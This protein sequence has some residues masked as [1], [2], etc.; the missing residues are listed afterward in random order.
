VD[1]LA[2]L[3]RHLP[4]T[5]A[6]LAGIVLAVVA[7][8][9][10]LV[11]RRRVPPPEAAELEPVAAGNAGAAGAVVVDFRQAGTHH[12]LGHAFRRALAE[13]RRHLGAGDSRY[14]LPW[15][16]LLG[17]EAADRSR[18]FPESGLN[19]PLG[20]PAEPS[21]ER[22]EGCAFWFFDR[23]VVIDVSSEYVLSADGRT[24]NE[25][26]WRHFLSLLREHRLERPLDG[27]VIAI[28][29]AELV[30]PPEG[31]GQRLTAAS[32]KGEALFRKLRQAQETLRMNFP[33]YVLVTGCDEI[34][35]FASYV[36]EIPEHLRGDLFGWSSPY[37]PETAFRPEWLDEAFSQL[38]TGLHRT[39]VDAFG[40]QAFL[41][42]PDGVFSFPEDFLRLRDPLRVYLN[43]IFR[44]SAYHELLPCRGLYFC[45]QVAAGEEGA[46]LL[47]GPGSVGRSVFVRDTFDRK[48]FPE[49]DLARPNSLAMLQGGRRL[50][51]LQA[52]VV[53]LALISTLGLWWSAHDLRGRKRDLS[54]F[55][56]TTAVDLEEQRKRVARGATE[57][58]FGHDKAFTLF[59]G[60]AK[61][62]AD[63]FG[64]VFIPS[65]W[66]SPFHRELKD[67]MVRAYNEIILKT[68][69]DELGEKVD[70]ILDKARPAGEPA[71]A[72]GHE[73]HSHAEPGGEEGHSHS[74][75]GPGAAAPGDRFIA[76]EPEVTKETAP[77]DLRPLQE[78]PDFK[79]L[80]QYVASLNELESQVNRFNGLRNT[81]SLDDLKSLVRF[82]FERDLP[83]GFFHNSALYSKALADVK[84]QR[85]QPLEHRP[86]TTHQAVELGSALF[87]RLFARDP[88][89]DDLRRAATLVGEMADP[90]VDPAGGDSMANLTELRTRL[91]RAE[92][93]LAAP[94]LAWLSGET[95]DLGPSWH[96]LLQGV[97]ATI[98]LGPD[99]ADSL[100]KDGEQRFQELRRGILG[101]ETRST[102]RLVARDVKSGALGLSAEAKLLADAL[103]GLSRQGFAAAVTGEPAG[104]TLTPMRRAMW[105]TAALQQAVALYKPYE[106][107][108]EKTLAAF[109][110]ELRGALQASARDRLGARMMERTAAARRPVAE[111]G[112]ASE[113]AVAQELDAEMANFLAAAAPLGELMDRFGKLGLAADRDQV[114]ATFVAQGEQVLAD[115]DRLLS[116]RSPYTPREGGFAWWKGRRPPANEAFDARD[117][118]DLAAYLGA[119]RG[120][121]A[122]LS[123]RYA[124]P[125]I[126]ALQPLG[127]RGFTPALR[128][129]ITRWTVIADQLHRYAGKDPDN[130][131]SG[132]E[133]FILKDLTEIDLANCNGRITPRMLAEPAAD[134]F[135]ERRAKLRRDVRTRCLVLAGGWAAE[136]YGKL[137]DFFNQRLAGRFPFAAAPP[138]RL[139]AE[140]EP[141]DLRAFFQLYDAYAP[142]VRG[143]SEAEQPVEAGEFIERMRVVR[144]LFASYLDPKQTTG[145][146]ALDL[147]VR[148]RENRRA[149]KGGDQILRWALASGEQVATHSNAR[150]TLPWVY[151]APVRL[152]LQW[153]KDSPVVPVESADLAGVSVEGRTAVVERKGRW[154]L[155]ALLRALA[156]PQDAPDATTQM[157]RLQVAT[158]PEADAKAKPETARVYIAVSLRAPERT[159]KAAAAK[160]AKD[161]PLPTPAGDLELPVF[162]VSAPAWAPRS[163]PS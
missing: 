59:D 84:Y 117:E 150:P 65:S 69:Y 140:A 133:R 11:R 66:F 61:L 118:A 76:W 90:G 146:P 72:E 120:E 162:P 63:W 79:R 82:L 126:Q 85:F 37:A 73:G 27:V 10:L 43:Q 33:V 139:D 15:Y 28:P 121:V 131:V 47:R 9:V 35:G 91:R 143:V 160:D 39:Q 110:S 41:E 36:G 142:W 87:D 148:F 51:V 89:A 161:A 136:G 132:L 124:A 48:V 122:D 113:S 129:W 2:T 114:T 102:G 96:Q 99:T 20:P 95:L 62:N 83:D 3:S 127:G 57:H 144:A 109:P 1:L 93:E 105:D 94:E 77:A 74:P 25:R 56:R 23:G 54:S 78:T 154:S 22:G 64:S 125:V 153:A 152:E 81:Q 135:L 75:G 159:D 58:A 68:L 44:A 12:R 32:E 40:D 29:C 55:L 134:F 115:A 101:L 60:M 141:E 38:S 14:R 107:L 19:L 18:L 24:Y 46:D 53:T 130:S 145:A 45:G 151:G 88:A 6:V 17:E 50:R 138:G 137:A 147:A 67:A 155:F 123:E 116:L 49:H 119:Q 104:G 97:R 13:L 80:N 86:R 128:R 158:R 42:D 71:L 7:V 16:L 52:V 21:P 98:F 8:L 108:T 34:P 5:L 4:L 149:E 106:E 100:Q 103:D 163:N 157:L 111:T 30:G 156:S 26:G 70:D 112:L 31:E 92:S